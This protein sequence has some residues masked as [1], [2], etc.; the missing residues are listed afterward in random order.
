MSIFEWSKAGLNLEFTFYKSCSLIRAKEP[1]IYPESEGK[2][3]TF[4]RALAEREAQK[5]PGKSLNSSHRAHFL[6]CKLY[7]SKCIYTPTPQSLTGL[8]FLEF[9]FSKTGCYTKVKELS[10]LYDLP[11]ARGRIVESMPTHG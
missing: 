3:D 8:N 10:L 11:I 1:T 2:Q 9:S 7:S 5:Y 4:P 6:R